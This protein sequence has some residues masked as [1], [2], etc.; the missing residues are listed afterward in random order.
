MKMIHSSF[1][2][3]NSASFLVQGW[4]RHKH[5]CYAVTDREQINEDARM[6]YYCHG[7]LLTV[8]D[9]HVIKDIDLPFGP[10]PKIFFSSNVFPSKW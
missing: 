4:K 2:P 9:R 6:G 1:L 10:L 3:M 8:E 5:S 7:P